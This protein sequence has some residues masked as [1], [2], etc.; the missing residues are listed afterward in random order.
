[1][2][3]DTET[4]DIDFYWDPVCPFAWITSRW[5]NQV[6]EQKVASGEESYRVDWRFISLRIVNKHIDYDS[7]FPPDYEEG[8][9]A[10]LR[11]LRVAAMRL[12]S[13]RMSSALRPLISAAHSAFFT[14]PSCSPVR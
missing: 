5:I 10:G 11:M 12:A 13:W 3:S 6:I 4:Y 7:H 14:T 1:M 8:H 9:T 2:A